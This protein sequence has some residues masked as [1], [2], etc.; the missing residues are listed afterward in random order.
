M[1][2]RLPSR[3]LV[4]VLR[5][6]SPKTLDRHAAQLAAAASSLPAE[7]I[8]TRFLR[9]QFLVNPKAVQLLF[10]EE[11]LT[12]WHVFGVY[13]PPFCP[14]RRADGADNYHSVSVESFVQSAL[15]SR[16]IYPVLK[17]VLKP[18]E[19]RVRVLYNLDTFASG[20][21]LISVSDVHR[22]ATSLQTTT[23]QYDVLVA[24]HLPV[25][26]TGNHTAIDVADLFPGA[27]AP[28]AEHAASTA[29][30]YEVKENAYYSVHPVSLLNVV[31]RGPPTSRPPA[32]ERLVRERLGTSVIG[33]PLVVGELM[34]LR[35]STAGA[36]G[37]VAGDTRAASDSAAHAA[38]VKLAANPH[39]VSRRGDIDF[40]RVFMHLREIHVD[41]SAETP[42]GIADGDAAQAASPPMA[43]SSA[44]LLFNMHHHHHQ[45]HQQ[46]HHGSSDESAASWSQHAAFAKA[47]GIQLHCRKCFHSLLQKQLS[48]S[49]RSR[50]MGILDGT[51]TP[52]TEHL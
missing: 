2:S 1:T 47:Q 15:Q 36:A 11:Q 10:T 49:V 7:A 37:T 39:I 45:Q 24:G 27:D 43:H 52:Q 46:Q 5:Q 50:R 48:A 28:A 6:N 23:M 19:V 4:D 8:Q 25:H 31:I 44:A 22:Y 38:A 9:N 29:A 18:S 12:R 30:H 42:S 41:T 34:H 33:D 51:W 21:V 35:A 32:L 13:K 3:R 14:M 26:G 16:D 20:P 40:P 17:R